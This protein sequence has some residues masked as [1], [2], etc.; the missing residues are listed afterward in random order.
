M[1]A[2][3]VACLLELVRRFGNNYP[4][5]DVREEAGAAEEDAENP[6]E[7]DERDV[8]AV[9]KGEAGADAGDYA[10]GSRPVE[11]GLLWVDA[12]G[13]RCSGGCGVRSA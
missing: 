1:C 8:P 10:R 11:A 9:V 7:T 4:A 3:S 5:D 13:R 6:D 2:L 12:G